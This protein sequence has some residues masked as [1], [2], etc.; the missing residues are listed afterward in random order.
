MG[1]RDLKKGWITVV[2]AAYNAA[3]Y[4]PRCIDSVLGQTYS[5]VKVIVVDDC[6]CDNTIEVAQAYPERVECIELSEN[7]GPAAG[8][9]AGLKLC[10]TEYVAFLDADDY[11]QRDFAQATT[12]F[13]SNRADAIAVCTGYTATDWKGRDLYGPILDDMDRVCFCDEGSTMEDFFGF[14][15]KY[16][17]ILTGTVLMRTDRAQATGGQREELRLTQDL[18]FWGYLGTFGKWGFIPRHLF[19]TDQRILSSRERLDKI[20][21]RFSFFSR[22][23]LSDWEKRIVP[24]LDEKAMAG[25]QGIRSHIA[26]TMAVANAYS[27]NFRKS[28][29]LS[30]K[31]KSELDRGLGTVLGYGARCGPLLFPLFCIAIRFREYFKTYL[32]SLLRYLSPKPKKLVNTAASSI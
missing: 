32:Y 8:R 10:D 29:K 31:W 21:R 25:F 1:D 30:K 22:L 16:R 17:N 9:N 24:R 20:K 2:I 12:D 13:L 27:L 5:K 14:W 23:R 18:E 19:I 6:S 26:T 15:S 4:I 28:Y 7:S 3:R 11:W